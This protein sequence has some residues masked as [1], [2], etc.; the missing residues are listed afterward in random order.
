MAEKMIR[1]EVEPLSEG[2][3]LATSD[4]LPGLVAQGRTV[5]E[6]LEIA[7]DVARKLIESYIEHGDPLPPG[8]RNLPL[9]KFD[10]MNSCSCKL[11]RLKR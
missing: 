9:P 6:T 11:R 4:G 7:Q 1:L 10:L 8:V 2:G 5:A 3:Y